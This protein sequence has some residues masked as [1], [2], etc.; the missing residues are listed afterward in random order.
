MILWMNWK[1]YST[2]LHSVCYSQSL[3]MLFGVCSFV[4]TLHSVC[5]CICLWRH[6]CLFRFW[7]K[8][9]DD[10]VGWV[11]HWGS[12]YLCRPTTKIIKFSR[13]R[14]YNCSTGFLYE[15][16][17]YFWRTIISFFIY[18]LCAI[19]ILLLM[20]LGGLSFNK[21]ST[22]IIVNIICGMFEAHTTNI[23]N[24]AINIFSVMTY[25]LKLCNQMSLFC[26]SKWMSKSNKT[27]EGK[28]SA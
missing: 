6:A 8:N 14:W 15:F 23:S 22:W 25:V 18:L 11:C 1:R 5:E 16:Y 4:C 9:C 24:I 19:K 2:C 21:R 10:L 13:L 26:L 12:R 3:C 17:R 28:T 7:F 27:G 20:E